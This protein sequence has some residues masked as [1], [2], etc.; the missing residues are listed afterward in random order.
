[1]LTGLDVEELGRGFGRIHSDVP[2]ACVAGNPCP[3]ACKLKGLLDLV[4]ATRL[5]DQSQLVASGQ[6]TDHNVNP[7]CADWF[8]L[9]G[10]TPPAR[11]LQ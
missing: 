5:Q 3:E 4:V 2:A 9:P 10:D 8:R 11:G 6:V 1:M 7:V